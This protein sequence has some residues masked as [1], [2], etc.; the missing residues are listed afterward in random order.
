MTYSSL[1]ALGVFL[2][3]SVAVASSGA[4]FRPGAWYQALAKPSWTPPNWAF[5]VVWSIL[6]LMIAI[7]GW[8]AWSAA[9]LSLPV[10]APFAL[11]M[12]LNGM[13]SW[14]FFGRRRPDLAFGDLVALWLAIA[15]TIAAFASVSE[16][17]A[18]L[19]VP[20]LIWVSIAGCLNWSVWRRNPGSFARTA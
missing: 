10:F 14:L 12:V 5:P 13:W 6:F 1:L 9:G 19:L 7:S 16:T 4:I 2:A 3:L 18:W 15:A 11:Q 17:A 8:L 20:Y